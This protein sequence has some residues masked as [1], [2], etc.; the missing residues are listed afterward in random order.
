MDIRDLPLILRVRVVLY[1]RV[2]DKDGVI[3][4]RSLARLGRYL[5]PIVVDLNLH[6]LV[7]GLAA[8]WVALEGVG[9]HVADWI[10]MGATGRVWEIL[11]ALLDRD[12][13]HAVV[14]LD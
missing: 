1:Q 8:E 5:V 2:A 13:I 14:L 12:D 9:P 11:V 7:G 4:K 3:H 6:L 10:I